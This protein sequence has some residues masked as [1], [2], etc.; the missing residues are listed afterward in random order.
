[1]LG[2]LLE[3]EYPIIRI[4]TNA[5]IYT[6]L[7]NK[8]MHNLALSIGLNEVVSYIIEHDSRAN[9]KELR[10]LEERLIKF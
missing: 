2:G 4:I 5:T 7:G 6:L 10:Y 3:S 8:V 9:I 1:V